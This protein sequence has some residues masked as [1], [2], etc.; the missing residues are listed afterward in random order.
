M[1]YTGARG[2]TAKEIIEALH[3][4]G[5]A[6]SLSHG[7]AALLTEFHESFTKVDSLEKLSNYFRK[8]NKILGDQ[9]QDNP[10]RNDQLNLAAALWV[11][12]SFPIEQLYRDTIQQCYGGAIFELDFNAPEQACNAI[13]EWVS[14][15]TRGKIH[16]AIPRSV[17]DSFSNPLQVGLI[18]TI[19]F[20]GRWLYPFDPKK[21]QD[22]LFYLLDGR[23]ISLPFMYLK[24]K[25]NW[26]ETDKLQYIEMPYRGDSLVMGILLPTAR[27]GL[28]QLE[29]EIT[30]DKLI[31]LVEASNRRK[32]HL[33]L[34][35]FKIES[36]FHLLPIFHQLGIRSAFNPDVADLTGITKQAPGVY[37]GEALHETCIEVDEEGTVAAV[38]VGQ[39]LTVLGIDR[40][41]TFKA[42]HP[43]LFL[44][45]HTGTGQLLFMGRWTGI[46]PGGV[47]ITM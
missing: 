25:F 10:R 15:Q 33:Y 17:F 5:S 1:L 24:E 39:F 23:T 8:R 30:L 18:N 2:Q 6:E 44:I 34:P 31:R 11:Q 38:L 41:P 7:M 20:S 4:N 9:G 28:P 36:I 43:F 22:Q 21:T 32:I 47:P 46:G 37:L 19:F 35:R 13:N 16:Q 12:R 29:K 14:R 26:V 27:D 42:D 3:F 40:T 45:R